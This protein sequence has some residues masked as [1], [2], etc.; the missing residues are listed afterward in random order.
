ML[1]RAELAGSECATPPVG[2]RATSEY[3]L[4]TGALQ[5]YHSGRD[6]LAMLM[7]RSLASVAQHHPSCPAVR[8]AC[9]GRQRW[10]VTRP[11]TSSSRQHL[12]HPAAADP[13]LSRAIVRLPHAL[14]RGGRERIQHTLSAVLDSPRSRCALLHSA[15]AFARYLRSVLGQVEIANA[16]RVRAASVRTGRCDSMRSCLHVS[17]AADVP[18]GMS[19]TVAAR[20]VHEAP[21]SPF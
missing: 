10:A 5:L 4:H 14:V 16:P 1:S 7:S 11:S 6:R 19:T 9:A 21:R 2:A 8:R 18:L 3:A 15:D 17:A 12:H 20:R 13:H